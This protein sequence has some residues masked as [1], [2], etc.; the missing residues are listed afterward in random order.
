MEGNHEDE[1]CCEPVVLVTRGDDLPKKNYEKRKH[2]T[3]EVS[4]V[5]WLLHN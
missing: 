3:Y 5:C 1:L 4:Y 2:P